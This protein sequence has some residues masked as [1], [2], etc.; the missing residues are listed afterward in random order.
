VS[1]D[2][3]R[4]VEFLSLVVNGEMNFGNPCARLC[5]VGLPDQL[6]CWLCCFWRGMVIFSSY[7]WLQV[8]SVHSCF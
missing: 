1:V 7:S 4:A 5:S 2:G 6:R 8:N 3:C